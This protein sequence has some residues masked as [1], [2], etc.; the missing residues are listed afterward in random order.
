MQTPFVGSV[1]SIVGAMEARQPTV[2]SHCR[3]VSAYAVQLAIQY[4]LSEGLVE[5]LRVG[6]L[7]HD[8]GKLLIPTPIL[9]KPGRLTERQWTTLQRHVE[10][11]ASMAEH[12]GFDAAVTQIVLGHHERIDG[13][14]YPDAVTAESIP[15][16]VRIVS[17]MDAFDAL[18][19]PRTYREALSIDAARILLA[20]EAAVR[21]C[22]W[23]VSGLLSL[24][25][26]LLEAIAH[27]EVGAYQPEGRPS[28]DALAG[29]T[30][31][32]VAA[33]FT[34]PEHAAACWA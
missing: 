13:S 10:L 21:Y 30:T 3:R 14:G 23:A 1:E 7:I 15:W 28:A 20:R 8:I 9:L 33:M 32:W 12:L 4:G 22:P 17:V 25:R 31:P 34:D 11:G 16:L 27:G 5:T 19:S 24:P 6:G 26:A 2:A 18:T 29:A